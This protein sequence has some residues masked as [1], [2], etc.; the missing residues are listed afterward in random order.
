MVLYIITVKMMKV[1]NSRAKRRKIQKELDVLNY[2]WPRDNEFSN[3]F[4]DVQEIIPSMSSYQILHSIDSNLATQIIFHDSHQS[5]YILNSEK[6]SDDSNTD[7]IITDGF[8]EKN[9]VMPVNTFEKLMVHDNL[10]RHLQQQ[11]VQECLGNWAVDCNIPQNAI[12]KILLILKFKAQLN[13][14]PKDCRTLL[15]SGSKKVLNLS[16]SKWNIFPFWFKGRCS[17]VFFN[18]CLSK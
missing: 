17:K 2:E 1:T 10:P 16:I 13:Y 7:S 18:N 5:S 3:L 12:N 15:H 9:S 11:Y 8:L 14:L 6:N 4:Q